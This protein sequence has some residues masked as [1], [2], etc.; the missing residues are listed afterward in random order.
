MYEGQMEMSSID[1]DPMTSVVTMKVAASRRETA[2]WLPCELDDPY[3][4]DD[5]K[6]FK[7]VS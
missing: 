1:F 6:C 2:E 3:W 4:Q 7:K 5:N